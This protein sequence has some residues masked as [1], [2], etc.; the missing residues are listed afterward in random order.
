MRKLTGSGVHCPVIDLQYLYLKIYIFDY[1]NKNFKLVLTHPSIDLHRLV[2]LVLWTCFILIMMSASRKPK[3]RIFGLVY[4]FVSL[5]RLIIIAT[6]FM[7][8]IHVLISYRLYLLLENT[9]YHFD[10]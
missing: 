4:K 8:I 7:Y 3:E 10:S 1:G 5:L 6:K 2:K 9:T